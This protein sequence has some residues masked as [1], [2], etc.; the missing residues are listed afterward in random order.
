MLDE[1]A[2][3]DA[4]VEDPWFLPIV[5]AVRGGHGSIVSLFI[6]KGLDLTALMDI[7]ETSSCNYLADH[8]LHRAT[9]HG[10]ESMARRLL[11]YR[12]D[13]ETIKYPVTAAASDGDL[14]LVKFLVDLEYEKD[15]GYDIDTGD[16]DEDRVTPLICAAE[17]GHNDVVLFLIECGANL[18]HKGS[19]RAALTAAAAEG[20]FDTVKTLI[21]AG[22]RPDPVCSQEG[23][24][25]MAVAEAAEAQHLDIARFLLDR[26]DTDQKIVETGDDPHLLLRAAALCGL[27]EIIKKLLDSGDVIVNKLKECGN[28]DYFGAGWG[29]AV[30]LAAQLGSLESIK[31]LL[32]TNPPHVRNH[33]DWALRSA[34]RGNDLEK[35]KLLLDYGAD[36]NTKDYRGRSVLREAIGGKEIFKMLL[37]YGAT[38]ESAHEKA[39]NNILVQVIESGDIGLLEILLE[40]GVQLQLPRR[41]GTTLLKSGVRGGEKM[42]QFLFDHGLSIPA[43]CKM[44]DQCMGIAARAGQ[45]AVLQF[46]L[47]RGSCLDSGERCAKLLETAS[48]GQGGNPSATLDLLL[49][50]G[51]DLEAKN[52]CG[53]PALWCHVRGGHDKAV[54]LLLNKGAD[55]LS[56]NR[57]SECLLKVAAQSGNS[58]VVR[59]LLQAI[60]RRGIPWVEVK[61]AWSQASTEEKDK[62]P[63]VTRELDVFYCRTMFPV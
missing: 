41:T 2:P 19:Y 55:P 33:M 39:E 14:S 6:E 10:Q 1:G 22:A 8:L 11:P 43:P 53:E 15:P 51:A 46:F 47:D 59:S 63:K 61:E 35:T 3:L 50:Y 5:V 34:I 38:L 48:D 13:P 16:E 31:L 27:D 44:V 30:S 36:P 56:R 29:E 42:M 52:R 32:D 4:G 24:T 62:Y 21:A 9:L 58:V 12:V 25:L 37:D 20:H 49:R 60:A 26:I 7:G 23:K 17:N 54:Q 18:E 45:Q 57:R 40:R 28:S